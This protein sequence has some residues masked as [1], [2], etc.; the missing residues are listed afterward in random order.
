MA[1]LAS[2]Q[3]A[4]GFQVHLKHKILKYSLLVAP[5]YADMPSQPFCTLHNILLN[6]NF[7]LYCCR[8]IKFSQGTDWK[9][10]HCF[11][12]WYFMSHIPGWKGMD[13]CVLCNTTPFSLNAQDYQMHTKYKKGSSYTNVVNK[14]ETTCSKC[15]IIALCSYQTMVIYSNMDT[16]IISDHV[17][18]WECVY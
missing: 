2:L 9:F 4:G 6:S 3:L 14:E 15:A 13:F 11:R 17:L 10:W 12:L 7:L 5:L 18:I 1:S 8:W 16:V